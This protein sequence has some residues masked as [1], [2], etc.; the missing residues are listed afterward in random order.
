MRSQKIKNLLDISYVALSGGLVIIEQI[1]RI[2]S[3]LN[4]QNKKLKLVTTANGIN[5]LK[6]L[7]DGACWKEQGN[8]KYDRFSFI[9]AAYQDNQPVASQLKNRE[10]YKPIY[11]Y[12]LVCC[13]NAAGKGQSIKMD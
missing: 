7:V 9:M 2:K 12:D 10:K 8:T 11:E 6:T 5:Q 4:N 3:C 1:S 13:W